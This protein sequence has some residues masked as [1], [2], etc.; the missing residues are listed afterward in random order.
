M[1]GRRA[2]YGNAAEEKRC[3]PS[4]AH[5]GNRSGQC[6]S[7]GRR[8]YRHVSLTTVF[9]TRQQAH[10]PLTWYM[11]VVA[12]PKTGNKASQRGKLCQ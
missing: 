6:L 10:S 12:T 4:S 9:K 1:V 2:E 7:G 3:N 8:K 5:H 11:T